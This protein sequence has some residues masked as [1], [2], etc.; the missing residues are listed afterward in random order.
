MR[1]NRG[2]RVRSR[3]ITCEYCGVSNSVKTP[4]RKIIR[5]SKCCHPQGLRPTDFGLD[6][7]EGWEDGTEIPKASRTIS[8]GTMP[9]EVARQTRTRSK[10]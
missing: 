6:L 10:G 7:S 2:K 8:L 1:K 4:L 9:Q 3:A 5:C